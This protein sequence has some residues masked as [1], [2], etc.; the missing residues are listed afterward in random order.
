MTREPRQPSA[1]PDPPGQDVVAAREPEVVRRHGLRRVL[2]DERRERL[3][4]VA[5]ERVDIA[6]E[7]IRVR[8]VDGGAA[9]VGLTFALLERRPRAL[10]RA[11]H[12]RDTG[13]EELRD[14]GRLPAQHL[15]EDENRALPRRQMLER[16]D[17]SEA[18]RLPR[19]DHVAGSPSGTTRPSGIGSIHVTRAASRGSRRPARGTARDP[20]AAR[21]ASA[22]RACRNTRSW[23]CRYSQER[24]AER[25]SNFSYARHARMNVS[26]TASSASSDPSMR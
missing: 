21:A 3:H 4:V 20:W 2:V 14:L 1:R 24:S 7:Q 12:R 17:E 8:S 6:L 18:N 11:V 5:L 23:R 16:R 15:A 19:L 13:L 26:C 25:P 22:P 10:E 9:V